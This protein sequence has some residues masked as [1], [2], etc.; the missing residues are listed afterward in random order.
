MTFYGLDMPT[1]RRLI[2]W[3][4]ESVSMP[5]AGN[6]ASWPALID[7]YEKWLDAGGPVDGPSGKVLLAA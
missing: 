7:I 5:R 3:S 1:W 2:A 4:G 6:E